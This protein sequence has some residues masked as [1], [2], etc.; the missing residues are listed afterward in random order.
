M[1]STV[2]LMAVPLANIY[3][4]QT[5]INGIQH[6][7]INRTFV[8]LIEEQRNVSPIDIVFV[9][10]EVPNSLICNSDFDLK[11]CNLPPR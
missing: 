6:I 10:S 7:Q 1:T 4:S 3:I 5:G 8:K 11:R 9:I 2:M